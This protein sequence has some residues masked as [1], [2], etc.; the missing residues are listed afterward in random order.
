MAAASVYARYRD[1]MIR[2]L[3]V[4]PTPETVAA[5]RESVIEPVSGA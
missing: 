5:F 4:Q 2:E 1:L 3:G